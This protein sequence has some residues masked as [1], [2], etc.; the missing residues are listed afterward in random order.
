MNL[1][2]TVFYALTAEDALKMNDRRK[3]AHSSNY[4]KD[5]T[6]EGPGAVMHYGDTLTAGMLLPAEVVR[7]YS[8]AEREQ[9]LG[10][11]LSSSEYATPAWKCK[12]FACA[13]IQ[14]KLPGNDHLFV[15]R[16]EIDH[17]PRGLMDSP[18]G[19]SITLQPANG[20]FTVCLPASLIE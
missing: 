19:V 20:K 9:E 15:R 4:M 16:A 7:M 17:S 6:G 1:G 3:D 12:T 10:V 14:V 13:D 2:Q 18:F 8:I 5:R 11:A